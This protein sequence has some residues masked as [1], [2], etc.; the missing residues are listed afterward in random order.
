MACIIVL[1]PRHDIVIE[2]SFIG[3]KLAISNVRALRLQLPAV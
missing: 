3:R 2:S 1:L